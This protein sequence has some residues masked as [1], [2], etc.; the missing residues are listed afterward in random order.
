MQPLRIAV[1]FSG[2]ASALRYLHEHDPNYGHTYE[3]ICGI[4]N[5]KDTR[6]ELFCKEK[7]IP[8]IHC[9]A[10]VFCKE[11]GYT[12]KLKD[13]PYDLRTLY[14]TWLK[15]CIESKKPDLVMLSG[16]MLEITNPLLE[17]CPIINVH[18]AD[19]RITD[20]EG[21]P[22]YTGDDAVT[23]AL[24]DGQKTTA[25]TIHVVESVVDQGKIICVS[26]PLDVEDGIDPK[27]H[28]EKMKYFCDGPAYREALHMIT[29]NQ[30]SF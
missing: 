26:E 4:S 18:P 29:S 16:F 13:M 17:Y 14:F 25:S 22:K 23:L 6:G 28:Q 11:K 21:K 20:A 2:S 27:D 5:K 15:D 9:N 1:L 19:L 8:F 12:G 3:V 30:L 7:E 24:A 10:K